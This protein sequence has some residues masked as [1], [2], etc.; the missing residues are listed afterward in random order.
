MTYFFDMEEVIPS[1]HYRL[2]H[3]VELSYTNYISSSRRASELKKLSPILHYRFTFS[4][5]LHQY[6]TPET[7]I[8]NLLQVACPSSFSLVPKLFS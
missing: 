8:C 6:Y 4:S 7:S 3:L 1:M 5:N 2:L